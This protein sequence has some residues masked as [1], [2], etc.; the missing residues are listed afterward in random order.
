MNI[1]QDMRSKIGALH[2][3]MKRM[4]Q[5]D[6]PVEHHF[7]E[8]VYA[9]KMTMPSGSAVVGKIHLHSQINIL[10]K[11]RVSVAT[12]N[13]VIEMTAGDHIVC[14]RGARRAFYAHEESVWTVILRCEET[15]VEK[16]E[17]E[18]VVE[19]PQEYLEFQRRLA[20]LS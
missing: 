18:F 12:D 14:E 7:C 13:G 16:I 10:S 15:D 20:C 2:D 4:G 9:R 1:V 3:V 5:I 19:T 8:G 17:Q 11:G 6:I